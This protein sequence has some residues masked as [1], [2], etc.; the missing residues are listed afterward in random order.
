MKRII[1][2]ILAAAVL[3]VVLASSADAQPGRRY[4]IDAGWQFNGTVSNEFVSNA[5]GW[6]AYAEGGYYILPR[7]A[8][9]AFVSYNT[10]NEYIPRHTVVNPDGSALTTD[11]CN[12]LFQVPFGAT[13][14]YRL[15]WKEFQPYAEAK[16][17]ADY[18]RAYTY[19]PNAGFRD[20][21]WGFYASPEI[22]FT[23]H[24]FYKS[25]FGFQFAVYYSYSTNRS[26]AFGLDGINNLGFKLGVSF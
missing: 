15:G 8:V 5:S 13:L 14:R 18:A 21:Q 26:E 1:G 17:G 24:P 3:C 20:T 19:F 23:W 6:G 25:N 16:I 10:N 2:N 9:G 12:S 22:G 7:I 4:Y 11:A